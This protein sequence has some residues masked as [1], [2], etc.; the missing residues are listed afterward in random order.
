M[1]DS[2]LEIIPYG[3]SLEDHEKLERKK[4]AGLR[5]LKLFALELVALCIVLA[6]IS[7]WK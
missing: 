5:G 1:D 3:R 7:F 2:P 6:A 4:R